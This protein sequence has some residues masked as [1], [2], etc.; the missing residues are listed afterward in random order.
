MGKV[1]S[2]DV[3]AFKSIYADRLYVG[4]FCRLRGTG[5]VPASFTFTPHGMGFI[6]PGDDVFIRVCLPAHPG[7]S[8]IPPNSDTSC[9]TRNIFF[10]PERHEPLLPFAGR[11][12]AF[13]PGTGFPGAGRTGTG[14]SRRPLLRR[15]LLPGSG[16]R[17]ALYRSGPPPEVVHTPIDPLQSWPAIPGPGPGRGF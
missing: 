6:Y 14:L 16:P 15:R 8:P 3:R 11:R 10:S 2:L 13:H 1:V 5:G 17:S 7:S 9:I 12:S 4:G